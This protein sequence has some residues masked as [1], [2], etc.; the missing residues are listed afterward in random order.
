MGKS[1]RTLVVSA[2]FIL[3]LIMSSGT[4][5]SYFTSLGNF[6]ITTDYA[7]FMLDR[8]SISN[9][10]FANGSIVFSTA[11][12]AI[13]FNNKSGSISSITNFLTNQRTQLSEN[14]PLWS[15]STTNG[16]FFS[17]YSNAFSYIITPA[18]QLILY[19]GIPRPEFTV[20]VFV[21]ADPFNGGVDMSL[22]VTNYNSN[23]TIVNVGFPNIGG[24]SRLGGQNF[25]DYLA[26]PRKDGIIIPNFEQTLAGIQ[27][28]RYVYP[29]TLSMQ[30]FLIYENYRGGMYEGVEDPGSN[31]KALEI[32]SFTYGQKLYKFNWELYSPQIYPGNQFTMNYYVTIA[33]FA[34]ISWQDGA[35]LYRNWV[36]AQ[37]YTE[38]GLLSTRTDVPTWLKNIGLI[39]KV[40]PPDN[41]TPSIAANVNTI[42]PNESVLLDLWGWNRWGFDHGYLNYFP[43][44]D[45]ESTLSTAINQ[46]H[47]EGDHIVLF[48][49]GTLVDTNTTTDPFFQIAQPYLIVNQQGELYIQSLLSNTVHVATADPTTQWWQS[50][51]VNFS[52]TA[53]KNYNADGV[54]LDGLALQPPV[55]NNRNATSPTLSGSSW[56]QAFARILTNVT[57]SMREY[58]PNAVVT[59]EGEN[60]VYIPYIDAFWDNMVQDNPGA[61]GIPG[62][63]EVP[64]FSFIYHEFSI[65]YGTPYTYSS[66]DLFRYTLSK[67][68]V[69]GLVIRADLPPYENLSPGDLTYLS[70]AIELEQKYDNYLRFGQMIPSPVIVSNNYTYGFSNSS[71]TL[72]VPTVSEGLFEDKSGSFLL[73]VSNPTQSTQNIGIKFYNGEFGTNQVLQSVEICTPGLTNNCLVT[74]S[75]GY[76]TLAVSNLSNVAMLVFPRYENSSNLTTNSSNFIGNSSTRLM[77]TTLIWY[78]V[79]VLFVAIIS[80]FASVFLYRIRSRRKISGTISRK[81]E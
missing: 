27:T 44:I 39:W 51:L 61:S 7:S 5:S 48:F 6:S 43:P 26:I 30:F 19:W 20:E 15:I 45:G 1:K 9:I 32:S 34:G 77:Q 60:E 40:S 38:R 13:A 47:S 66:P 21:K 16:T 4:L 2:V 76:V 71:Y 56:W 24:F 14:Y 25:S 37:W 28:L 68:I 42:F 81:T 80:I 55:L 54:Y 31:L 78:A 57:E 33:S 18:S 63:I 59:S 52:V 67:A 41:Q 50:E 72:T 12:T 17:S 46:I 23:V 53:V 62:A 49:S 35:T 36:E 70:S 79:P 65:V 58:N 69:Y 73:A 10:Q 74:N 11:N 75:S 64:M 3:I 29:G 8:D 22:N